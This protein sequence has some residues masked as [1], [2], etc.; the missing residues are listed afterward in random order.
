M[1]RRMRSVS[2]MSAGDSDRRPLIS[3]AERMSLDT[4][5]SVEH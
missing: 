2:A 1:T 5:K 3:S 4:N